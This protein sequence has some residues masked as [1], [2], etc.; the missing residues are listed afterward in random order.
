MTFPNQSHAYTYCS[1]FSFT[2]RPLLQL[3][4]RDFQR[5]PYPDPTFDGRSLIYL[6]RQL[7]YYRPRPSRRP[8]R[9]KLHLWLGLWPDGLCWWLW[10]RGWWNESITVSEAAELCPLP[11]W[12]HRHWAHFGN[13]PSLNTQSCI[14]WLLV[15]WDFCFLAVW[16]VGPVVKK[17]FWA[18]YEQH[19][20]AFFSCLQGQKNVQIYLRIL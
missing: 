8:R 3:R 20:R 11:L 14:N 18:D 2:E 4:V 6:D 10:C 13:C 17:K 1:F 12:V 16:A 15:V 5:R 19:F 9:P 7:Q